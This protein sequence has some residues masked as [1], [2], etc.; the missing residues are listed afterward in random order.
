[1]TA[2]IRSYDQRTV[3]TGSVLANLAYYPYTGNLFTYDS[4]HGNWGTCADVVGNRDGD[5]PLVIHKYE[6]RFP[7][8]GGTHTV[9]NWTYTIVNNYVC[10]IFNEAIPNAEHYAPTMDWPELAWAAR[11]YTDPQRPEFSLPQFIGEAGD[12]PG[13]LS[14]IPEL[15]MKR[16]RQAAKAVG[17]RTRPRPRRLPP[18]AKPP[19]VWGAAAAAAKQTA[20]DAGSQYVGGQFGWRPVM[21]DLSAMLALAR[22]IA[23]RLEWL[24]RL[25]NGYSIKR[26]M[27]LSSPFQSVVVPNRFFN[28]MHF[29]VRGEHVDTYR[30]KHWVTARWGLSALVGTAPL[31]D[32]N[33]PDGLIAM[34][35]RLATGMTKNGLWE[36]WWELLPWSWLIDWW[37]NIGRLLAALL[38][39]AL[40]L[41]LESLCYCRTA[42][43]QRFYIITEH[44]DW[45]TFSGEPARTSHEVKWRKDIK[46][47]LSMEYM[48]GPTLGFPDL[49]PGQWAILAGLLAQKL[50]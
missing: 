35:A 29:T 27:S 50:A 22:A 10:T 16:G 12:L 1:M 4:S 47:F 19:S 6:R 45:I 8:C 43:V 20:G 2:R 31:P 23:Q 3:T 11:Q 33:D 17:R 49:N 34:A 37:Y 30:I 38:P 46:P 28:T 13:L 40:W 21:Q 48:R 36:A 32:V 18:N 14:S 24:L 7:F 41:N 5:N 44:P 26:R 42:R 25:L 15:L 9:G 39:G